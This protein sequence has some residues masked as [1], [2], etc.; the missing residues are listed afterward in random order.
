MSV[1]ALRI[2]DEHHQRLKELAKARGISVNKLFEHFTIGAIAEFDA[3]TRFKLRKM[4]A[5][6]KRALEILNRLDAGDE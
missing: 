4:G 3:E 1:I 2:Q 6:K 5:D